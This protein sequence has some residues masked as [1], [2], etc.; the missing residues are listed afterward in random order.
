MTNKPRLDK[1]LTLPVSRLAAATGGPVAGRRQRSLTSRAWAAPG[2][3]TRAAAHSHRAPPTHTP[4]TTMTTKAT[5]APANTG[6]NG[7]VNA[8]QLNVRGGP[9]AD[10]DAVGTL[11]AGAQVNLLARNGSGGWWLVCCAA[12]GEQ[13][14]VNAQF[15]APNGLTRAEVNAVLVEAAASGATTP[16]PAGTP[17]PDSGA[18]EGAAE[19]ATDA[20]T[21]PLIDLAVTSTQSPKRVRQG[22]ALTV[23]YQLTNP[24]D[25]AAVNV[26][27][28][29]EIPA[30]LALTAVTAAGAEQ[31]ETPLASG[32]TA[33][34]L[35]W[36]AI[37][38]G[39]TVTADV[40]YT[41]DDD[42]ADGSVIDVIAAIEGDN[43]A[44]A[45]AG[46]S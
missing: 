12:N 15:V 7:V 19:D 9:G 4:P 22:D 45:G 34:L 3:Q 38:P 32:G 23:A 24:G 13:G 31:G 43:V 11:A 21:A 1:V 10:F 40:A 18:T 44:F 41:V 37:A 27:L 28:R 6:S 35:V 25:E 33:V 14:W 8:V 30:G 17:A 42:V 20:E 26:V 2:A 16:A 46:V 39:A 5:V 36:P 29:S